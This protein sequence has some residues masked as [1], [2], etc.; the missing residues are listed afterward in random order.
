MSRVKEIIRLAAFQ[1][2]EVEIQQVRQ[3]ANKDIGSDPEVRVEIGL[4]AQDPKDL[5]VEAH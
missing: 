2:I 5:E 4:E 3:E 1:K